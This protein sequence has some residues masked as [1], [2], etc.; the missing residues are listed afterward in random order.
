MPQGES[1][2]HLYLPSVGLFLI[3][4]LAFSLGV[5]GIA[6]IVVILLISL[7]EFGAWYGGHKSVLE[8]MSARPADP[9]QDSVLLHSVGELAQR[10]GI[11]TP[12]TY[13]SAEPEAN[14]FAMS[15]H[16]GGMVL[17]TDTALNLWA[18]DELHA[19]LAH[20]VGHLKNRDSI[21]QILTRILVKAL[22]APA[23]FLVAIIS[24]GAIMSDDDDGGAEFGVAFWHLFAMLGFYVSL[25][26]MSFSSRSRELMA[27]QMAV[28]LGGDPRS[29][30]SAL[31]KA[32]E[33]GSS[34]SELSMSEALVAPTMFANPLA[35]SWVYQLFASHPS[36]STRERKLQQ[37]AIPVAQPTA[38]VDVV[39]PTD[40]PQVQRR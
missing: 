35:D 2:Q 11:P 26:V 25:L 10:A 23:A 30:I 12:H 3:T 20:E 13:I 17:V 18:P 37:R 21:W 22:L 34:G 36:V 40:R 29:L 7:W 1:T 16:S 9:S 19:V 27:D 8:A 15:T 28:D 14:A 6:L 5:L 38:R 31:E 39:P 24:I 33:M 32:Q 4:A